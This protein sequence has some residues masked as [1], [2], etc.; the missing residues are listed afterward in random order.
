MACGARGVDRFLAAAVLAWLLYQYG[1][2]R[3]LAGAFSGGHGKAEALG[4]PIFPEV[5]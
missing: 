2:A 4:Y 1:I 5:A 3:K